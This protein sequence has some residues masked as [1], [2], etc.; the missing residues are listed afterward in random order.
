LQH[1]PVLAADNDVIQVP[2]GDI[3]AGEPTDVFQ[4][5]LQSYG[6]KQGAKGITLLH[7]R[8]RFDTLPFEPKFAR[9]LVTPSGPCRQL[10]EKYSRKLVKKH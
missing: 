4:Q 6:E 5:R 1:R 10:G 7:P 3:Y 2:K 8:G 9:A